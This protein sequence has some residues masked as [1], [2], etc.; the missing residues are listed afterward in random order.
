VL[1]SFTNT[2]Q[3][4][5]AFV[6]GIKIFDVQVSANDIG[7]YSFIVPDGSTYKI[8]WGGTFMSWLELR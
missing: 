7:A 5:H 8:I 6:N 4:A 2:N 1:F 3:Q